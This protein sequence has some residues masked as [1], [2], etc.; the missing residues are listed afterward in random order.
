MGMPQY[1]PKRTSLAWLLLSAL[2]LLGG[3]GGCSGLLY[4]GVRHAVDVRSFDQ[5]GEISIDAGKYT[6]YSTGPTVSLVGP[7]GS[8]VP[9]QDYSG[10]VSITVDSTKFHAI[11]TF[12]ADSTGAYR[13]T[14]SGNGT[15]AIGHGLKVNVARIGIGLAIGFIAAFAAIV[16]AVIVFVRRHRRPP[17]YVGYPN[18]QT[19]SSGWQ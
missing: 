19:P 7:G 6:L 5:S 16:V 14:I 8:N 18:Y 4:S 9:L 11:R 13:L 12:T 1:A 2:L 3:V 10:D 17:P 15:V